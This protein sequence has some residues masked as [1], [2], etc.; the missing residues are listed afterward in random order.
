MTLVLVGLNHRTAPVEVRERYAVSEER[1]RSIGEKLVQH[2]DIEEAAI[3]ATCN[4][5]ELLAVARRPDQALEWLRAFLDHEIG[6]ASAHPD[7]LYERRESEAVAHVFRVATSLDSMVLGEAQILGQLKAAHRAAVAARSCGPLINRLF[8]RAF[9]AAKRVRTE[10]GL[11]ASP[12]SVARVGVQLAA[13][14]FESFESK[15]VLLVGAGAMAES[16]LHGLRE[17]G[18]HDIVVVNRTARAAERLAA[19]LAGRVAPLAALGA[20]LA[21]ADVVVT[22]AA[23]DRP[24]LGR[25][26]VESSLVGRQGRPLLVIDLGVPR[27]VDAEVNQIEDVYLYD[28]D[29]LD[30][31]AERGR[32]RRLDAVGPAEALVSAEVEHYA[33]WKAGL[34]AVATIRELIGRADA[35]A[36]DEV[37][38]A[39]VGL[40]DARP[41]LEKLAA[42]LVAKLLHDALERL[43]DEAE[44]GRGHYFADAV[45]ELF[46]LGEDEE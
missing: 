21:A 5:T 38:R 27:N 16:A 19:R 44:D 33:R 40:P 8:E 6:D 18:V 41:A 36:Q 12:V 45:R 11:G 10:T 26:D 23:V 1:W 42:S 43:R 32:V 3:I 39:A 29:G 28:L 25:A 34:D 14:I 31:I 22:S 9:R 7:Q 30:E 46:G 13:E 37:R 4:R 20:E 15:R 17:A 35:L 2:P 24:L